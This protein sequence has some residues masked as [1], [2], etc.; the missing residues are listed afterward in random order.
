[1]D[2]NESPSQRKIQNKKGKASMKG[3]QADQPLEMRGSELTEKTAKKQVSDDSEVQEEMAESLHRQKRHSRNESCGS[4]SHGKRDIPKTL[5]TAVLEELNDDIIG[6]PSRF[7]T[8]KQG[9]QH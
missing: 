5:I 3:L 1:M 4:N 8:G 7:H 9:R 2:R 6:K